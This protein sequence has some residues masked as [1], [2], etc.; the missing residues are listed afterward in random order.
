MNHCIIIIQPILL[1]GYY[2]G[3]SFGAVVDK[4]NSV[5]DIHGTEQWIV[6]IKIQK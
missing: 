4:N 1:L 3:F 2:N 5:G 6:C